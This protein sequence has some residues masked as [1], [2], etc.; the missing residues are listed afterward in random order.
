[1]VGLKAGFLTR[2]V[3]RGGGFGLIG[4]IIVGKF[5]GSLGGW[6]SVNI[7]HFSNMTGNFKMQARPVRFTSSR[8][9]SPPHI[10]GR[11]KTDL[12]S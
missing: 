3:V 8:P 7:L 12:V 2:V 5:G 1:M 10:Q 9:V 4:D 11:M 6:I